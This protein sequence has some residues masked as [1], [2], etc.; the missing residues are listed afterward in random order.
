[1]P[2]ASKGEK[3]PANTREEG[4][5]DA[6]SEAVESGAGLPGIARAAAKVLDAS[7][8]L[9]DRSSAVLAVAGASPD[10][11]K[12]LLAGGEGVTRVEL[13]VADSAVGELRYR[14]TAPPEPAIARMVTTLL[15]LELERSRSPE[16]ES[17]EVAGVFVAAVL[18]REV[19]DRGDIVARA[20]ELGADLER[21]AGVLILHAAPRAAQ[22]G[23]WRAR[24]LTLA[25]R[26]LRS[27]AP[28]SLASPGGE[29]AAEIAVIVP[30]EDDVRI[31]RA[32][33]GLARELEDSLSGFH[34]TIGRSR[35]AADPVD[36]Y[37]SGNEARL[38]VNVGEAEGRSLLAFEDTGSYRLLL[39]AMSE[40]P[41]E[42][43]RFYAETIAPL[44]AYDDQYETELVTTVEA[45]LDNDG[46]VA[47]TA[48]Q[49]FTHRHTI[50]YRLE[51]VKE[52]CGHD[53]SASEGREKLSL[54]L[55]TM[56]VLGIASPRGPAMEPGA[57]A[58]KVPRSSEE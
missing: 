7:V 58:G 37:R 52:L 9:I 16:W 6:L 1:M 40:D 45:Y 34:L 22:T 57:E 4:T 12:K 20:A 50:R 13:R 25:Q 30:A 35:H 2:A 41:R 8:A 54:G 29:E 56:R 39:P 53:V 23:E 11:E 44:A 47:A 26:A 31:E 36:L 17:E 14:S 51:R 24:V 15:A 43:E 46:N 32:A 48:K 38:A 49:L 19:T 10:Q 28:G 3:V 21:G 27:L 42:L 5:L 33:A 55:K 18:A